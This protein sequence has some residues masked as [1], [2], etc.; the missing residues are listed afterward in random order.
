MRVFR[1]GRPMAAG[2]LGVVVAAGFATPGPAAAQEAVSASR[3]ATTSFDI[4]AQDLAAAL[5]EYARQSGQQLLFAPEVVAGKQ[6]PAVSGE[7]TAESAL[8]ALLEGAGLYTA[9]T[10]GGA[11]LISDAPNPT[12]PPAG[13]DPSA[14]G[15]LYDP[16]VDIS[17]APGGTT[18]VE[19]ARRAGVE[20]II[21]TGQKKSE[22]LQDVPIA[23]SAFSM[24]DLDA[25]KIE[26]GFDLLKGVP[27]VTFTKTNFTGYNFQI[28]G[29]GTQAISA[30]TDP[31]VAVSFNNTTMI[32]NR[33]FE[34]EYL[35]IERVE[36]LRGPQG[37]LYGRNATAGV[38]NVISAKPVIGDEFGE[39]KLEGGNYS[40]KRIR[41]H[42]NL[43]L[44]DTLAL[45]AAYGSTVREGYG[46]NEFDG[47]DVDDR[48]LWTGRLT[49]G[50]EPSDRI[51][52]NL[53][54]ER[55][56]EDDGRVRSTKQL[57]HRDDGVTS[58]GGYDLLNSELG[59]RAR[60]VLNQG[61]LPGSLY[62]TDAY[63]VP[64]QESIPFISGGRENGFLVL[65]A[66][67]GLI[68]FNPAFGN[69]TAAGCPEAARY[70]GVSL[71]NLCSDVFAER[72][73]S[74][75]LRSIYSV[76]EPAYRANAD[77]Y[78]LSLD[79][80]W[81][82][83]VVFSSQTVFV[84]DKLYSTQDYGR[85][86]T[87]RG[88]FNDLSGPLVSPLYQHLTP[89]GEFC[90]PQ[91]GCSDSLLIQD[92]SQAESRQFNQEFRFVSEFSGDFNFSFGANYTRFET[93]NDYFVF[94]NVLSALAQ[95]PPF[96]GDSHPCG[97]T[98]GEIGCIYIDPNDLSNI[99]AEGHNYFR[100]ANPYRL[101]STGLFGELY[102][103]L[104]DSLKLTAGLRYTWDR[105]VFTPVPSQT[106]LPDYR[107]GIAAVD[108]GYV[109]IGDGPEA[110]D[111]LSLYCGILGNAPGG[112][113]YPA[114]PDIVQ[115]WREPTGRIVL[116][117]QP[118]L[119]FTDETLV[120]A[121][122]SRGYKAGGANPPGIAPPAGIFIEAAR[123]A[124]S[125]PTFQPEYV[126]AYEVGTKN[127]LFGGLLMLNGAAFYYDY[128]DYQVSKIIDRSASNENFDATIW[129]LELEA[130]FAPSLN[131]QF[132]A[133]I[134]FLQTEIAEGEASIDLMDRTQ[135]GNQ[136][137][138][139][140]IPNP[141][142][143]VDPD[144]ATGIGADQ[145]QNEFLVFDE[146]VVMKPNPTQTANCVA[147]AELV[148]LV[149]E[150]G[151]HQANLGV[152]GPLNPGLLEIAPVS[153]LLNPFC[154]GG[155]ILGTVYKDGPLPLF[156][157]FYLPQ[158]LHF[159]ALVD[160]PNAGAGFAADVSGNELPNSP[161]FTLSLGG[162]F[163]FD[164]SRDW[165]ATTRVDYYLQGQSW[166][167][168]YNTE[169]DRL[170]SW[171]NT[172]LSLMLFNER[173]GLAVEAYVKNVFDESPI[174]GTFLNS[175]DT[176]LTT[177]V[178]TLDPRLVGVSITKR[179]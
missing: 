91:L 83:G 125:S 3:A 40:A 54:W 89:G 58:V 97:E 144:V 82:D 92:V 157:G 1:I 165:L 81:S 75:D 162:Q 88:I 94:S 33:L 114:S 72:N 60:G 161:E 159:D 116:D 108:Q 51:R 118:A 106:L 172:N 84:E 19:V 2:L 62:S 68:G 109:G 140:T 7:L 13:T 168:V 102:W 93:L 52:V 152:P 65:A 127:T 15:A 30:T 174:T 173:H 141:N 115:V 135:G 132:N 6:A 57:C 129:G 148:A 107:E 9:T 46:Y 99:N 87:S 156:A 26:G 69:P 74:Q 123:G 110:C 23:I 95:T 32:V 78:D 160:A 17:G 73:Q 113:G 10:P 28:R 142:Y 12:P 138:Q 85:F 59:S 112:R 117:W 143:N 105:K 56:E 133:A 64:H 86:K 4:P 50:W 154:A 53:M 119:S 158:D 29:I 18:S 149:L 136:P 21:V 36:V 153:Y 63:G 70:H 175:D 31:G 100:S 11:V 37:T 131:W 45:R 124:V 146:W 179:F 147:P 61:C 76:I 22:R 71:L 130:V 150:E 16:T 90:D 103:R 104:S 79:Y 47:S 177:N 43:P 98:A 120:Y 42:Y 178:F 151:V 24:E 164:L 39:V 166:A 122:F 49:L 55:I 27:N 77:V 126:N 176:G 167:R 101:Q 34:Q 134:G 66:L 41:G 155:N 67:T 111:L 80:Q 139:T 25:Q 8:A 121:S 169:Y 20:E 14:G 96:T 137:Y 170:R 35:D 171:S 38:I 128:T 5:S 145:T 163:S 48:D 44:G